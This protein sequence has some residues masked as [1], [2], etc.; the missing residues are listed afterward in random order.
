M[1]LSRKSLTMRTAMMRP[2]KSLRRH[3]CLRNLPS[4]LMKKSSRKIHMTSLW[5]SFSRHRIRLSRG[6]KRTPKLQSLPR[7]PRLSNPTTSLKVFNPA[8]HEAR[9]VLRWLARLNRTR[10]DSLTHTTASL[11]KRRLQTTCSSSS[12]R[13]AKTWVKVWSMP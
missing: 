1:R 7:S 4:K 10:D 12:T 8:K 2:S 5:E 3:L 11:T 9:K 13:I 6:R